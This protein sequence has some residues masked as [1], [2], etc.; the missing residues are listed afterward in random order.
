[1]R[2]AGRPRG[3]QPGDG[4]VIQ[5]A[6]A[7]PQH[8]THLIQ[9]VALVAASG[10]RVLLDAAADLIDDAEAELD[11]VEGVQHADR[12]GQLGGQGCG[13]SAERVERGEADLRLPGLITGGEP[14]R[15][16]LPGAAGQP[17]RPPV[18]ARHGQDQVLTFASCANR[19]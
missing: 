9:R 3:L 4:L 5:P 15:V 18:A 6:G 10:Q 11:H 16:H 19:G 1:V 17:S 7:A 13:V 14:A 8:A 12:A 2:V